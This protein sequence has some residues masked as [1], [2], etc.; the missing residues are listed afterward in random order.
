MPLNPTKADHIYSIFMYEEDLALNNLQWLICHKTK[1]NQIIYIQ[2]ICI[3]SIWYYRVERWNCRPRKD[4]MIPFPFN[5]NRFFLFFGADHLLVGQL[6]TNPKSDRSLI[7]C[8]KGTQCLTS[9]IGD[10]SLYNTCSLPIQLMTTGPLP[11]PSKCKSGRFNVPRVMETK[12]PATVMVFGMVSSEGHIMPPHIFEV[13]LKVNTKM[14][15]DVLKSVVITWCN[16]VAGGRPWVWQQDSAPGHKS[17][18]TQAWLQ[19]EC[20]EFVPFTLYPPPPP[21]WTRWTTSFG[22]TSRTSPTW[23]PKASLIAAIRRVFAELLPV[24][25][26]KT[27]SQFRIRIEVVIEAEGG[28]I[29]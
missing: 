15:L 17:K 14:Y 3:K 18:V 6:C 12:F 5:E 28:Y 13:G 21:I 4:D 29:E 19:K 11:A 26:K 23:P 9:E 20:Y 27:C 8:L 1:P 2:H 25:V 16:Q 22:H 7:S 10:A 24:L